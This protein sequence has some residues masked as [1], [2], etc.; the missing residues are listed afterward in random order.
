[1][2]GHSACGIEQHI[3]AVTLGNPRTFGI[4]ILVFLA[5]HTLIHLRCTESFFGLLH[6]GHFT[7]ERHHVFIEFCDIYLRITP[8]EISL[9]VI[10][11]QYRWVDIVPFA[12][13]KERFAERIFERS[14][15]RVSYCY[16]YCHTARQF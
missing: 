7:L 16:A 6:H 8:I 12:I 13:V 10:V 11:N 14:S 3:L 2:L 15:W 4:A 5:F 1:M 9:S